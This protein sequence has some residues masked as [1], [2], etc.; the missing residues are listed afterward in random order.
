ML[1]VKKWGITNS[2][3]NSPVQTH[4]FLHL[5]EDTELISGNASTIN[6]KKEIQQWSEKKPTILMQEL[7]SLLNTTL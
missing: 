3:V 7:L 2:V 1:I 6:F 4:F 5:L